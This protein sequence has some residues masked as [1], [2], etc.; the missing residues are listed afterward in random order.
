MFRTQRTMEPAV[1]G[2]PSSESDCRTLRVWCL[3]LG[4]GFMARG[5]AWRGAERIDFEQIHI[6]A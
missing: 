4:L 3:L 6:A 1:R 5:V 2:V